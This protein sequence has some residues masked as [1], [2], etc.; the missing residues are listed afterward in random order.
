MCL[1]G[2]DL[3]LISLK[4]GD[5]L[6]S[7]LSCRRL[8]VMRVRTERVLCI[9][10]VWRICGRYGERA[11]GVGV[12]DGKAQCINICMR[13]GVFCEICWNWVVPIFCRTSI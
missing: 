7:R 2:V 3:S 4:V 5:N 9:A 10:F 12:G 8:C 13:V 6:R 1:C 11:S